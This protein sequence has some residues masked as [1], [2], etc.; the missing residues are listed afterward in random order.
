[1]SSSPAA[2]VRG[3]AAAGALA[4]F[5]A[6]SGIRTL[7][8]RHFL[9]SQREPPR[10]PRPSAQQPPARARGAA[11]IKAGHGP[12]ASVAGLGFFCRIGAGGASLGETSERNWGFFL[13]LLGEMFWFR[14]TLNVFRLGLGLGRLGGR[15]A[16]IPRARTGGESAERGTLQ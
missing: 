6:A 3:L 11:R 4:G 1:M 2:V 14:L 5:G 8:L 13:P 10:S 9:V 15:T 16:V 12:T 7:T